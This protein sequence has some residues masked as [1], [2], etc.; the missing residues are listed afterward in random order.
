MQWVE[1]DLGSE[2]GKRRW[3]RRGEGDIGSEG[4]GGRGKPREW[5]W[6]EG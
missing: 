6:I 1:G 2:R 4:G 3:S 5:R